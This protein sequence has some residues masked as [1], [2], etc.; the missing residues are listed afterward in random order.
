MAPAASRLI[1]LIRW[2]QARAADSTASG[3]AA[4]FDAARNSRCA[5]SF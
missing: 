2:S 3:V 4:A 5:S 1:W